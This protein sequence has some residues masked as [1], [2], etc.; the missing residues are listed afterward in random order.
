MIDMLDVAIRRLDGTTAV[1]LM[2]HAAPPLPVLAP[3]SPVLPDGL[4]RGTTISVQGSIALLLAVLAG[5]SAAGAW[6]ALVAMPPINAEAAAEHGIELSRLAIVPNPAERW[7]T[8]IGSLLDA[9]DIVVAR[10]PARGAQLPPADVRRLSARARNR[11][12]I[13]MP[14]LAPGTSWPGADVRLEA[15]T[16]AWSGIGSGRGRLTARR[17]Q[18]TANGRGSAARPRSTEL[19]LPARDGAAAA[20]DPVTVTPAADT[21]IKKAG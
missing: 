10:P 15:Q 11:A 5:A 16:G 8:A 14:Y 20:L 12:S 17:L 9:V 13:L 19:W 7:T 2:S 6:C 21:W 3:L 1:D 4:R 18:V